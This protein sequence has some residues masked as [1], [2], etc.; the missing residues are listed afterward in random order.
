MST[1]VAHR[2]DGFT[3]IE[4]LVS[5]LIMGIGLLGISLLQGRA[6]LS[7]QDALLYSQ[8]NLLAY[9]LA[10]RIKADAVYWVNTM[11]TGSDT[12]PSPAG[13]DV[14]NATVDCTITTPIP[15][16][17]PCQDQVGD[18]AGWRIAARDV[19]VWRANVHNALGD[20]AL[21]TVVKNGASYNVKITWTGKAKDA[22]GND[23][24]SSEILLDITP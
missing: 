1:K 15:S 7:N 11:P 14:A 18:V 17:I 3:L 10:D 19:A 5:M 23:L 22:N 20:T 4:V 12:D 6:L 21:A 2:V 24:A 16:P 9:D 8:A 13:S